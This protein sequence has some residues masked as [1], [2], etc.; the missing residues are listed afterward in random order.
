MIT[1][2]EYMDNVRWKIRNQELISE[3]LVYIKVLSDEVK[4]IRTFIEEKENEGIYGLGHLKTTAGVLEERV[5]D[6][7]KKMYN[8]DLGDLL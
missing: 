5:E 7:K 8:V 1:T 2:E 4:R 6:L 3:Q